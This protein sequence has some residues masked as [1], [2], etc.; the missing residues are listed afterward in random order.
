MVRP[1]RIALSDK[2]L[3]DRFPADV[4]EFAEKMESRSSRSRTGAI[5]KS[6]VVDEP[7]DESSEDDDEVEAPR[8][9]AVC[10]SSLL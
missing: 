8:K 6:N 5:T 7:E 9:R 10:I 3:T 4:Q 2:K 1:H